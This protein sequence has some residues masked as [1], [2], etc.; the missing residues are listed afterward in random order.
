MKRIIKEYILENWNLKLTALLLSLI[1]WLFVS[2]EP[3]PERIVSVPVEVQVPR[4]MEIVNERPASVEV[5]MRGP[6]FSNMRTINQPLPACAIDMQKFKEGEHLVSLTGANIKIPKGAS[7]EVLKVSPA[8]LMLVLERTMSKEVPVVALVRGEPARGFEIYGKFL[9]PASVTIAGPRSHIELVREVRTEAISISDQQQSVRF[10]AALNIRD[11]SI[12]VA[13][14]NSIQVDIQI[15]PRLKSATVT[16][17]PL[18]ID[19]AGFTVSPRKIAVQVQ[20][21]ADIA[22]ALTPAYFRA[23]V[24]IKGIEFP[25]LPAKVKPAVSIVNDPSGTMKIRNVIPA[26]VTISKEGETAGNR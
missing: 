8:R 18:I 11:S 10:F 5:T 24:A 4:N 3:G 9:K 26:E 25:S 23:I 1:L 21:P 20:A 15:G 16:Q 14:V 2:G 19:D 13:A 12:R 22:A 7:V 6:A 17:V